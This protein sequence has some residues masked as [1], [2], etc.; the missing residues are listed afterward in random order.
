[1]TPFQIWEKMIKAKV[2]TKTVVTM[3]VNT[4]YAVGQI[5]DEEYAVLIQLINTMYSEVA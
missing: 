1:M 4:V 5:N 3:R 2:Y